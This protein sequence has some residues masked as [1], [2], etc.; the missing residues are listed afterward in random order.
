MLNQK[1]YVIYFSS[2][3]YLYCVEKQKYF[4][5]LF[6]FFFYWIFYKDILNI[7][8]MCGE[9]S[10]ENVFELLKVLYAVDQ[11]IIWQSVLVKEFFYY[12]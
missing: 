12:K 11:S 7:S 2:S 9:E 10:I 5:Y 6:I 8:H 3:R 4:F 1:W